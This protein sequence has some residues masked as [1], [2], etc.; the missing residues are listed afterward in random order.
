MFPN[1][2]PTT[3][4]THCLFSPLRFRKSR[5]KISFIEI[6]LRVYPTSSWQD[7][8]GVHRVSRRMLDRPRL[9]ETA[10]EATA[11][12]LYALSIRR[13]EEGHSRWRRHDRLETSCPAS[14]APLDSH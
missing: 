9:N 8:S 2:G 12:G 1:I 3:L 5:W 4:G 13:R 11:G 10:G 14:L 7:C 6:T